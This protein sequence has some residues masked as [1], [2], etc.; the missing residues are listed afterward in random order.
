MA[1]LV[2]LQAFLA[3]HGA[4]PW[5]PGQL[6]CCL[7]LADWAVWLGHPDP[8][9]HLR[10][11]Y[12]DEAGFYALVEAAGGVSVLV[13]QCVSLIAGKR[14]SEPLCGAVG[15]I[16]SASNIRRQF[17]AIHDGRTWLFRNFQGW[18]PMTANMIKAW[19][20]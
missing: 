9:A 11:T 8:A 7:A 1:Q 17:G 3:D 6:D 2:T 12:E 4:K 15:V 13:E 20:I 5:A 18:Q 16:G 19:V 10:G 14:V